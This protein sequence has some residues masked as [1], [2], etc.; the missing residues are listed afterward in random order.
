M[1]IDETCPNTRLCLLY[2]P[3]PMP[4]CFWIAQRLLNYKF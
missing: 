2:K 3:F 1:M 4:C